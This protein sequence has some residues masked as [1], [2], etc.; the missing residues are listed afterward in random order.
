MVKGACWNIRGL[1]DTSKHKEVRIFVKKYGVAFLGLLE[2]RVRS[3]NK[4]RVARGLVKG[5]SCV[6]N[7]KDLLLGRIWVLWNPGLVKFKVADISH[8]A[9]H[10]ELVGAGYSVGVSVV[11]GDCSYIARRELWKELEAKVGRFSTKPWII[12]GDF[13][14]SRYPH[15][16]SGGRGSFS[17]AM[18]E[19][20]SCIQKCELEDIR[21]S[22]RVFTSDNKRLGGTLWLRS[23]IESWGIGTALTL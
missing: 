16:H 20:E 18:K 3:L 12:C 15:E 6:R 1:N 10:G 4:V 2:T 17:I 11:Y 21:Q 22:G 8:Q 23:W 9:I 5:W 14:V 19:F 7:H 13:N